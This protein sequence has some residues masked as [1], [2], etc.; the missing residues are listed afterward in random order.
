MPVTGSAAYAAKTFD[1][2]V[3]DPQAIPE[4]LKITY[5]TACANEGYETSKGR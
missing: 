5:K 3:R 4:V 2:H 1:T